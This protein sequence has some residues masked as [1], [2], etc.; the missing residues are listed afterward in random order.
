MSAAFLSHHFTALGKEEF[1]D[2]LRAVLKEKFPEVPVICWG[3]AKK[4]GKQ[5]E[6]YHY[7]MV[8]PRHA[9]HTHLVPEL[10]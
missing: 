2:T 5:G 10:Q 8:G 3:H 9:C 4:G 7:T 6:N 1:S